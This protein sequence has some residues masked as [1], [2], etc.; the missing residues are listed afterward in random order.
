LDAATTFVFT[1]S[2]HRTSIDDLRQLDVGLLP[3]PVDEWTKRK[4]YL[5]LVQYMALGIP[6]VC[7][8][9]GSNPDVIENGATG[10]LAETERE[11]TDAID[12]LVRDPDLRRD[13]GKRAAEVARQRYTLQ[14]KE[15][16]IVDAFH[17][18]LQ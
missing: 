7:T 3:L 9:L 16:E 14:A 11:W 15:T 4:F 6:A 18:A 10:F 8:P 1:S 12:R 5:K 17:C 13:L 2:E